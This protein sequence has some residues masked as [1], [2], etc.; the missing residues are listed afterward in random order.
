MRSSVVWTMPLL[1]ISLTVGEARAAPLRIIALELQR[2]FSINSTMDRDIRQALH[3]AMGA[4]AFEIIDPG[5][6]ARHFK[7]RD[8]CVSIPCL[9]R[10]A[11][12]LEAHYVVGGR[13]SRETDA[14]PGSWTVALWLFD[15]RARATVATAQR[16]CEHCGFPEALAA[17]QPAFTVLLSEAQGETPARLRINSR[18]PGAE[19]S[20][21]G[22]PVGVTDMSF[23]VTPGSQV[24]VLQHPGHHTHNVT[25]EVPA[26]GRSPSTPSSRSPD[27]RAPPPESGPRTAHGSTGA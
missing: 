27:A 7:P 6:V 2:D 5:E 3:Q 10:A 4:A 25:V 26:G 11:R 18:P 1:L 12:Q 8:P 22:R 9:E 19:V 13:I 24:V 14:S 16:G 21:N 17:I 20:I 23:V 15:A